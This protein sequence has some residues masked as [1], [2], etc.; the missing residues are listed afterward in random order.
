MIRVE[1]MLLCQAWQ[2]RE[3]LGKTPSCVEHTKFKGRNRENAGLVEHDR[4]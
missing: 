4:R 1:E 2:Q 3:R